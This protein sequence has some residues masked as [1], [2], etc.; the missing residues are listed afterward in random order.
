M[1]QAPPVR[2]EGLPREVLPHGLF[3]VLQLRPSPEER[4]AASGVVWQAVGCDP[5]SGYDDL[6][7]YD[8]DGVLVEDPETFDPHFNDPCLVGQATPFTVVGSALSHMPGRDE[9]REVATAA[10]LAGE[11][12]QAERALWRRLALQATDVH[13]S[14][15]LDPYQALAA[16]EQWLGAEY[17]A[18]GA[19]HGDRGAVS[20]LSKRVEAKGPRLLTRI[21]TPVVAGGGYPGTSPAGAAAATGETWLMA[22]PALFGYRG[23]VFYSTARDHAHND[24]YALALRNYVVGFDPCGVAAVRM[25]ID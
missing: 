21:G 12:S 16:L 1:A 10:L 14:G 2:V 24:S 23:Q 6:G 17:G 15:A 11:Q 3:S 25:N 22:S 13:P 7:C 8:I 9:A 18:L 5:A 19:A 4:E 20:L